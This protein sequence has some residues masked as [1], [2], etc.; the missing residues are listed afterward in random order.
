MKFAKN[1][2]ERRISTEQVFSGKL[3]DVRRDLA[4]LPDESKST[5]EWIKHPGATA[6]IPVFENGD[7]LLLHQFRYPLSQIFIEVPAGKLDPGETPDQTGI[8]ELAEEAGLQCTQFDYV[9]HFYPGIGYSDEIIH[10][11]LAQGLSEVPEKTDDDEFVEPFRVPFSQA[12][13]WALNG[14][15][16]DG[17]TIISLLK[18]WDWWQKNTIR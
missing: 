13:E 8:R 4:L 10:I 17:K 6:I 14:T 9:G 15:I 16:S 18:A 7:I 2:I 12:V 11:Y 5:R 3:L 1:L